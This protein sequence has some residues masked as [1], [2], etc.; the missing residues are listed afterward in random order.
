[1][2]VLGLFVPF[3]HTQ[4]LPELMVH[5]FTRCVLCTPKNDSHALTLDDLQPLQLGIGQSEEAKDVSNYRQN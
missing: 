4:L 2:L 5:G 3:R 1:M